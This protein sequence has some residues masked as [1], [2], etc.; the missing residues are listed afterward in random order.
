[1]P[2]T[3][4]DDIK[5]THRNRTGTL[6]SLNIALKGVPVDSEDE[7]KGLTGEPYI[8]LSRKD[9]T[10][11]RSNLAVLWP[12]IL[13]EWICYEKQPIPEL[14]HIVLEV[15]SKEFTQP[16]HLKITQATDEYKNRL[17]LVEGHQFRQ[18]TSNP[19]RRIVALDLIDEFK[20][21]KRIEFELVADHP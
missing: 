10:Q 18:T 2:K 1:M 9:A 11:A 14:L 7:S 20:L 8:L 5:I 21:V 4:F 17:L 6:F 15:L 16:I 19:T 13:I 12:A 3:P